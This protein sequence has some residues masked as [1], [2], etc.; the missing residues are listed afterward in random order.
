MFAPKITEIPCGSVIR[1]A[2]TKPMTITVVADELCSTAVTSAPAS[3]PIIGFLVRK[4]RICFMRS[5]AAFCRASLMLFMP[6]RN[7]ARPP[8]NPKTVVIISFIISS[9]D[10]QTFRFIIVKY[11]ECM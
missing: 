1:P 3:A 10:I 2:L 4:L 7:I 8:A 6:N 9:Y 11:T 5:P